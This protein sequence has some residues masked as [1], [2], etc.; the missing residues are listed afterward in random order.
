MRCHR[1][2]VTWLCSRR[3]AAEFLSLTFKLEGKTHHR[4]T[5]TRLLQ[6]TGRNMRKGRF[7]PQTLEEVLNLHSGRSL[8]PS[9]VTR[10]VFDA[11]RHSPALPCHWF[12]Y[13]CLI[14]R[15]TAGRKI[16]NDRRCCM[17]VTPSSSS[18]GDSPGS[19]PALHRLCGAAVTVFGS[20]SLNKDWKPSSQLELQLKPAGISS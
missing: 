19:R 5:K 10:S 6:K 1:G 17:S 9:C 18:C 8:V 14:C 13:R 2:A 12:N 7:G 16:I 20:S 3:N 4:E 11:L 15:Q